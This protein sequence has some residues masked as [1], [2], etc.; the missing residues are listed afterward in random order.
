MLFYVPVEI[1]VLRF[2]FKAQ[3]LFQTGYSQQTSIVLSVF[4]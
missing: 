3:G 4:I 2:I 1:L